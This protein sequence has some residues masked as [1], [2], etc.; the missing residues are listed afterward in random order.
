MVGGYALLSGLLVWAEPQEGLAAV[1]GNI[2]KFQ[3]WSQQVQDI[4]EPNSVI[5]AGLTDKIFWPEREVI[6]ALVN[7][8]DYESVNKLLQADTPVYWF[9][10]TWPAADL[11]TMNNRLDDYGLQISPMMF[12]WQD[13]S[14]YKIS[15]Q[16]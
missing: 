2:L 4:T 6:Y 13:F 8:I 3:N 7:P 14:L 16:P 9:H 10:P 12:G 15:L 1:R 11:V 5:V